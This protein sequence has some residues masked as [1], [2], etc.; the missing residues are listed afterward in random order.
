[1]SSRLRSVQRWPSLR[2][3]V[4]ALVTV[5]AL[6]LVGG[7]APPRQEQM[8]ELNGLVH[9]MSLNNFEWTRNNARSYWPYMNWTS[10]NCSG[11]LGGETWYKLG[12]GCRRHD[13]SWRNLKRTTRDFSRNPAVWNGR[14]KRAA[15][16]QFLED[17]YARCD[18]IWYV[19]GCY[20]VAYV[21]YVVVTAI[22]PYHVGYE[23]RFY[24]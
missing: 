5:A 14:N 16:L 17:G 20:D 8:S 12:K 22:A 4:V 9:Q 21:M 1:M 19:V 2:M 15:D 10:D 11:P 7:C 24:W 18:E 6:L 3:R 23:T 13:F